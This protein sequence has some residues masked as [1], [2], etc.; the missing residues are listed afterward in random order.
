F[1]IVL[2]SG[3]AISA[4]RLANKFRRYWGLGVFTNLFAALYLM[5]GTAISGGVPLLLEKELSS[6]QSKVNSTQPKERQIQFQGQSGPW[7]ADLLGIGAAFIVP[8]IRLRAKANREGE[9]EA[10]DTGSA[11]SGKEILIFLDNG[12]LD[13]VEGHLQLRL[14]D[15]SSRFDMETIK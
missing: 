10:R 15:A 5:V 13:H 12:I 11:Q 3:L 4:A 2:C 8:G 9:S 1:V 7:V 14:M 6:I